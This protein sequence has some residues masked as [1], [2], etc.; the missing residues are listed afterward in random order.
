MAYEVTRWTMPDHY[1]GEVW[2]DY[3]TSGVG[4]SRDSDALERANFAAMLS[5]L[6]GE[7]ETVI[8][9]RERHWAV[10]WVEWIAIHSEDDKALTIARGIC[11]RLQRY[12]VV[13]EELFSQY[14]DE[15]CAQ[16]W[17]NCY[18]D[19]ERAQYL[20]DHVNR[21]HPAYGMTAYATLRAA[22]KGDWG[23]AAHLLPCP[24]DLL[25]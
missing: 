11:E 7:S 10:G 25:S 21:V 6:G 2:P 9:V 17:R 12:P 22:V 13:D 19:K 8:V 3:Y 16:T 5:A 20:R 24:S 23:Y 18:S 15:D 4:Q 1:S 14:E